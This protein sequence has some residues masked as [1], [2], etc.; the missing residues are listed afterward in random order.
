MNRSQKEIV[1]QELK[2]DFEKSNSA[3]LVKVKG[4]TVNQIQDLRKGLRTCDSK[5]RVAKDRLVK[6]AIKEQESASVLEPYLHDQL[7]VVFAN[8][9]S[10]ATAK[11][12][13]DFAKKTKL[14]I[15][16]GL[17]ESQL[18]DKDK[19]VRLASI[20]SRDVLLAQLCGLL[21][22]PVAGFARALSAVAEKKGGATEVEDVQEV[23]ASES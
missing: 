3:F 9:D 4:L 1:V 17:V 16:V 8:T 10:A 22:A 5:V 14:E 11:V 13:N 15:I 20:P 21:N 6:I 12:I 2:Q 19:V 18:F 7:A 23:A